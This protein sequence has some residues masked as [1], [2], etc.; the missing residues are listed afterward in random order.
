MGAFLTAE[1]RHVLGITYEAEAAVL[2]PYLPRGVELD[3]LEGAP[4]VSVVAFH[5][6]R[7]RLRG[8]PIPLHVNFPEINLRTYVRV[9]GER[10]V[11]FLREFVSRPAVSIIARVAYNEP[12]RT[13]R[14]RDEL[15][16][17]PARG[18]G[19]RHRFGP[20]LANRLEAWAEP[21]GFAPEPAS[22]GYWLTHHDLGVGAGRDGRAR[23]YRVEH[24]VWRLH[25]IRELEVDVD[26]AALYGPRWCHLADARPSHVTFASGSAITISPPVDV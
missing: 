11:V 23:S 16:H 24:E 25:E 4:R 1:W 5:F 12:Y 21:E 20:R 22:P 26:F 17:D 8:L 7:T 19:V 15:L 13:I 6:R 14:M 10:A 18:I 9:G 2:E 3:R